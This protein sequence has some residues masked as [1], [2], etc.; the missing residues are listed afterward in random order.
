MDSTI[1]TLKS[2][3]YNAVEISTKLK[4][5]RGKFLPPPSGSKYSY[6]SWTNRTLK[7]EEQ[8]SSQTKLNIYSDTRCYRPN[9]KISEFPSILP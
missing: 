8:A 4:M 6:Y 1:R 5:F 3:G 7:T 9:P 2:S